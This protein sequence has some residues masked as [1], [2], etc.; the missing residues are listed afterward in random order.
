M[1]FSFSLVIALGCVVCF[2]PLAAY[3]S[4]L[5]RLARRHGPTAVD[6]TWDFVAVVAGLSGFLLFGGGLILSVVQTNVRFFFRGNFAEF[7]AAWEQ[8]RVGWLLVAGGYF[9]LVVGGVA[10]A[11]RARRRTLV[12]YNVAPDDAEA[13][14]AQALE[15]AAGGPVE[16]KGNL[17]FAAGRP[18]VEAEPFEAGGS[19]TVRGLDP[20]PNAWVEFA[21]QFRA[22]LPHHPP[23]ENPSARWLSS[24]TW[25]LLAFV[26]CGFFLLAF[27][28]S[29]VR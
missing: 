16:R 4:H 18:V 7:R 21:R 13:A 23:D 8:E 5:H 9:A 14:V 15:V 6:G 11:L 10:S 19:V 25:G 17:W 27:A 28:L 20:E 26:G 2:A 3:L 12:V 1:A 29:L 24:A 22:A